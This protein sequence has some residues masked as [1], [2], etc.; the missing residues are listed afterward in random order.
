VPA[1]RGTIDIPGQGSLPN[2]SFPSG[3]VQYESGLGDFNIFDA[4]KLTPDGATTELGVGPLVVAPT[5]TNS[6]LGSGKWQAGAAG[7][8]IHP[9]PGGSLLGA[10]IT[11]QHDFA[12]DKD[13]PGTNV[14]AFQPI[15]TF[16]IG[17][18]YYVRSSAIWLFDF[19]NDRYLFPLGLG[20]G[21]VFK[22][23]EAV[24]N[25]FIEPQFSVYHKGQGLPVWQLFFGMNFQWVK[26]GR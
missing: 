8:I 6:A 14:A 11:W 17:G 10:L 18:G 7:V 13:R 5:A 20:V 12:G 25:A 22:V 19:R 1:G 23:G 26:K 4:I 16:G 15:G 3:P 21:K 9:L 2:V 24:T